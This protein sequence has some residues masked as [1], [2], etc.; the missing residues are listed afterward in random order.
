LLTG[1]FRFSPLKERCLDACRA[2]LNFVYRYDRHGVGNLAGMAGLTGVMVI[3]KASRHGRERAPRR[4]PGTEELKKSEDHRLG[5]RH[6]STQARH[7]PRHLRRDR[8][9]RTYHPG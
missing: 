9:C 3:E 7:L 2:P 8:E 4:P 1:V 5:D 6:A